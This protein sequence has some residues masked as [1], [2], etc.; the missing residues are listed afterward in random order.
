LEWVGQETS[1]EDLS[2][3]A[4]RQ[5]AYE[6]LLQIPGAKDPRHAG[7]IHE[8]VNRNSSNHERYL[9]TD[10]GTLRFRPRSKTHFRNLVLA[11]DWIR[12]EVDVPNMEGAVCS[13]YTAASELLSEEST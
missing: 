5:K 13:G 3:E 12:N 10:P 2:D 7:I 11:G 6:S 4:L 1:F 9:L 8:S